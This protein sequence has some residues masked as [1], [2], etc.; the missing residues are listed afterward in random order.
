[1]TSTLQEQLQRLASAAGIA[2]GK[3]PRGKPSLLYTT[4]NAA[5]IGIQDIYAVAV[6]GMNAVCIQKNSTHAINAVSALFMSKIFHSFVASPSSI[7]F[8]GFDQ[9]CRVDPRFQAY[10]KTLFSQST[11]TLDRDQQTPEINSK[12][13]ASI[14]GFCALLSSYFLL[15]A[16]FKSLEYLI[17]RFK[18][19]EMNVPALMHAAL[20]YHATN[21]FVRLVQILRLD[22]TLFAFLQPM[23]K[24]GVALPRSLLVQRCLTDRSLLRFVCDAAQELGGPRVA[25]RAVMPF[26]AAL[27]CEIVAAVPAVDEP[28]LSMLLPY[29]VHGLSADVAPDYRA[30]VYMALVQLATRA[31]FS[32]DLNAALVLELCKSATPAGLPQALLVLCHLGVTQPEFA[33]FPDNA[34]KHLAK[35]PGL[36]GELLILSSKGGRTQRLLA[37]VITAAAGHV[38]AHENYA[39]LM[40]EVL[41]TVLLGVEAATLVLQ[42]LLAMAA[43]GAAEGPQGAAV[44]KSLRTFDLRYP[45]VTEKAVNAALQRL[46]GGK[47]PEEVAAKERLSNTLHTAFAGSLRAPMIEAG[48]TL[49]LA[50]DAASA[51]IRR[52]ALEKLD[53]LANEHQHQQEQNGSDGGVSSI[54]AEAEEVLRGALLR[55]LTDDHP[56]VVQT[57]LGLESL[58]RLPPAALLE[59]LAH[60]LS[61]ALTAATQKSTK[62]SDRAAARGIA[63]KIVK[64]LAGPF[65]DAHPEDVDRAAELVLTAVVA[66]PHTRKVAESAVKKGRKVNHPL[67]RALVNADIESA[68]A[69]AAAAENPNSTT[70][71]TAAASTSKS[72]AKSRRGATAVAAAKKKKDEKSTAGAAA[73]GKGAKG[74]D[75]VAHNRAVIDALSRA[76]SAEGDDAQQALSVLLNS[77]EPRTRAL[78]LVVVNQAM[79]LK[80]GVSLAAAVLHRFGDEFSRSDNSSSSS[81]SNGDEV[82]VAVFGDGGKPDESTLMA[83]ATGVLQPIHLE[84][85][86]VLTALQVLPSAALQS[87]GREVRIL[88]IS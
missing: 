45:D 4:Q 20:P 70:V 78:V 25:A 65:T 73:V 82:V 87:L 74:Y 32:A 23:Q 42:K 31:T 36:S 80:G 21:E 11:Q 3:A 26:F 7:Y 30:A 79:R 27:L 44:L 19:H 64:L 12:L 33:V 54:G 15:P 72:P 55:R 69:A 9:L 41:S 85:A 58:L 56:A 38:N 39:R 18:V 5:D 83:L 24:S 60:C 77:S 14:A 81:S 75:D 43:T 76:S 59:S 40:D 8:T 2:S 86:V 22:N 84:P 29:I 68:A 62:K 34:F 37:L 1:M 28:F 17:R 46:S 66:A 6:Q 67:L 48:T 47:T 71:A 50:V 51:G 10:R 49:A 57:A 53:A 16:A 88:I 61:S 52:L 35:L 13:D 63:R